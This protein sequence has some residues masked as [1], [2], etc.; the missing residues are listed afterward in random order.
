VA[1][2]SS[3]FGTAVEVLEGFCG[4]ELNDEEDVGIGEVF[5]GSLKIG[6]GIGA[7]AGFVGGF[8]ETE[9]GWAGERPLGFGGL[10]VF[11]VVEEGG[12]VQVGPAISFGEVKESEG[13]VGRLGELAGER[14]KLGFCFFKLVSCVKGLCDVKG[15]VLFAGGA[16]C[17]GRWR[18]V[19]RTGLGWNGL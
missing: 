3:G 13:E 11:L 1:S 4:V 9:R 8:C 6:D 7:V 12:V 5:G 14:L 2:A 18:R 10:E 19:L 15:E 16:G 17:V